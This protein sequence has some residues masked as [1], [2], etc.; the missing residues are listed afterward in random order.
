MLLINKTKIKYD[1]ELI[2]YISF[3]ENTTQTKVHDLIETKD[4]MLLFIVEPGQIGK[5]VGKHGSNV[6]RMEK[7]TNRKI[8]IVEFNPDIRQFV[9]NLVYPASV[10]EVTKEENEVVVYGKDSMARSLII[11]RENKNLKA[12]EEI[13]KRYFDIN[14]IKVAEWRQ[15]KS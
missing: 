5:A 4:K 9:K 15:K 7:L 10:K 11:G 3:F 14:N 1:F 12:T 6:L 8:K 2:K 13:I